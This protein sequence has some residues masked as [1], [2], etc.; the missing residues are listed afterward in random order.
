METRAFWAVGK[1]LA[2]VS[3]LWISSSVKWVWVKQVQHR[4]CHWV[5]RFLLSL[6]SGP[7]P[8]RWQAPC[9]PRGGMLSGHIS[10]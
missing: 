7:M 5:L 10:Q 3:A 2:P 4:H 8:V 6:P 1:G 9:G